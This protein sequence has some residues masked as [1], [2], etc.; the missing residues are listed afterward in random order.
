MNI[1]KVQKPEKNLK[2]LGDKLNKKFYEEFVEGVRAYDIWD[3]NGDFELD[4][5]KLSDSREDYYCVSFHH[6]FSVPK[7][8]LKALISDKER[9]RLLSPYKEHLAQSFA[10]YFMRVGLPSNI[11]AEDIKNYT[12]K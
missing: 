7:N 5:I 1:S 11:S 9:Y 10:R 2:S 3:K 6:I 12:N 8:Y 4:K